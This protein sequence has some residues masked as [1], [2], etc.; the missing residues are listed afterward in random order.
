MGFVSRSGFLERECPLRHAQAFH[1][2]PQQFF[3]HTPPFLSATGAAANQEHVTH[4]DSGIHVDLL[5]YYVILCVS[6]VFG[7]VIDTSHHST[8]LRQGF[9]FSPKA[10]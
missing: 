8:M 2:P 4:V 10:R 6:V 9:L 5:V 1:G 3:S 7:G